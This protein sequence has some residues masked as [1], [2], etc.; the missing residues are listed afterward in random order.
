MLNFHDMHVY[1]CENVR[2]VF[3]RSLSLKTVSKTVYCK[4]RTTIYLQF[5]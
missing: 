4:V 5:D 1:V 3:C 2:S